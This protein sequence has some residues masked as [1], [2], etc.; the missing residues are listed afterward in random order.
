MGHYSKINIVFD[1]R[2]IEAEFRGMSLIKQRDTLKNMIDS[3]FEDLDQEIGIETEKELAAAKVEIAKEETEERKPFKLVQLKREEPQQIATT[4]KPATE[5]KDGE[6]YTPEQDD[7]KHTLR[8]TPFEDLKT[9]FD[10]SGVPNLL[11][12]TES[13]VP[14]IQTIDTIDADTYANYPEDVQQALKNGISDR[15]FKLST[16]NVPLYQCYYFCSACSHKGKRF[17]PIGRKSTTCHTCNKRMLVRPARDE[18]FP[19]N[20]RH[21][22]MFIAGDYMRPEELADPTALKDLEKRHAAFK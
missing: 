16:S 11:E 8:H 18:N 22:N 7:Q 4:E 19:H 14:V 5:N 20:D 9:A 3:F 1:E 21:G 10:W 2:Q 17:I 12:P 15:N 13:D 6:F